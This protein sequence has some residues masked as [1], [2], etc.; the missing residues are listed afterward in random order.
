MQ[1][2]K[3]DNVAY[4]QREQVQV[5]AI[6]SVLAFYLKKYIIW[7]YAKTTPER[8]RN[9]I[10]KFKPAFFDIIIFINICLYFEKFCVKKSLPF[11]GPFSINHIILQGLF[12]K[13]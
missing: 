13:I 7:I 8:A 1:K 3:P 4:A 12:N 5:Q 2:R 11:L 6:R 10:H 9:F